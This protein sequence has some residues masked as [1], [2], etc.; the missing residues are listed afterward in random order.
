[1]EAAKD[2]LGVSTDSDLVAALKWQPSAISNVSKWRRDLNDPDYEATWDLLDAAGLLRAEL[3]PEAEAMLEGLRGLADEE[4]KVRF[5]SL[6]DLREQLNGG[7][8]TPAESLADLRSL[9]E[10]AIEL[11]ETLIEA[12]PA[13]KAP[14][15]AT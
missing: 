4:G 13:R 9:L 8:P 14:R 3:S 2:R 15:K 6:A 12:P 1:M 5:N 10:R 11:L 7:T